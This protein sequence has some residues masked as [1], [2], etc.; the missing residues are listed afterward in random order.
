[1]LATY[2]Q[3][4][5]FVG[6]KKCLLSYDHSIL[7]EEHQVSHRGQV[8]FHSGWGI[9]FSYG[10]LTFYYIV[11]SKK[12]EVWSDVDTRM[13]LNGTEF[14]YGQG[15]PDFR[16]SSFCRQNTEQ[17]PQVKKQKTGLKLKIKF[18]GAVLSGAANQQ[19]EKKALTKRPGIA[20]CKRR[21]YKKDAQ[22]F[23]RW[24][25]HSH[26]KWS[27]VRETNIENVLAG[28]KILTRVFDTLT[29]LEVVLSQAPRKL[30]NPAEPGFSE[31]LGID[32]P[33]LLHSQWDC[34]G[35]VTTLEYVPVFS[36]SWLCNLFWHIQLLRF[37]LMRQSGCI[38][39]LDALC[40]PEAE[41]R[42]PASAK[43]KEV[44]Q[45]SRD[46]V[47]QLHAPSLASKPQ[48]W[49]PSLSN[50]CLGVLTWHL[51]LKVKASFSIA[52]DTWNTSIEQQLAI[53]SLITCRLPPLHLVENKQM[54]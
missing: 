18:N 47:I 39:E 41:W 5:I 14:L 19:T 20:Q 25:R 38:T 10:N 21:M 50:S 36:K 2:I 13:L 24:S 43:W 4:P 32:C 16:C 42:M 23:S 3:Q 35:I 22:E 9:I 12:K 27:D 54:R 34:F 40:L 30:N 11:V 53:L 31:H 49:S 26:Q 44:R 33:Y 1:M 52:A 17:R 29:N 7:S 28:D 46:E 48:V 37:E 45:M 51:T 6:M 8:I 15:L